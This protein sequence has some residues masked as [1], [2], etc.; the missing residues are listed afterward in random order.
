MIG[1][2]A[3]QYV[4]YLGPAATIG[5]AFLGFLGGTLINHWL[6]NQRAERVENDRKI[7]VC[8][9]LIAEM[10]ANRFQIFGILE[11]LNADE[12]IL[13]PF[14]DVDNF[15][16]VR[17]YYDS[18]KGEV[19][20]LDWERSAELH[21]LYVRLEIFKNILPNSVFIDRKNVVDS[22]LNYWVVEQ[23][24]VENYLFA[25][26]RPLLRAKD[27]KLWDKADGKRKTAIP[28]LLNALRKSA[29]DQP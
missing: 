17:R 3:A 6:A 21:D 20:F 10:A 27:R 19:G 9:G 22:E 25:Y 4:P 24:Y 13:A 8:Q 26:Q 2:S 28:R 1:F 29:R 15:H 7:D 12:E 23:G 16:V 5:S 11:K 18:V 14:V